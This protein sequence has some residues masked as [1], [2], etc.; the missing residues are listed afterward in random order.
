MS[1]NE[2]LKDPLTGVYSRANLDDRIN[3][4]IEKSRRHNHPFTLVLMDI[5]H[6]K[7]INDGFGHQ[8]GD[9]VLIEFSAR[10][11]KTCRILDLIF[12]FGGDE[13]VIL[14]P[15]TTKSDAAALAARLLEVI[16][17]Q[18]FS[19]QPP[20][21]VSMSIGVSTYPRDG[22]S[23]EQLFE[24]A[25][26]R[27]YQAKR[28]GRACVV[29]EDTPLVDPDSMPA[30]S[31]LLERDDQV[32]ILKQFILNL[33]EQRTGILRIEGADGAGMTRFL[34][35][36]NDIASLQN[37]FSL[38]LVGK[39]G[40][41]QRTL[42]ALRETLL[43]T[44]KE[45]PDFPL[46]TNT[47][48]A[49][50]PQ[51]LHFMAAEKKPCLLITLDETQWIDSATIG[52][53]QNLLDIIQSD[54]NLVDSQTHLALAVISTA[55]EP[56]PHPLF[57]G[58]GNQKKLLLPALSENA[59]SI[60]I[61][62]TLQWE[63]PSDFT[64][65][66]YEETQGLA[67]LI[68]QGLIF[69]VSEKYI[70]PTPGGWQYSPDVLGFELRKELLARRQLSP[71]NLPENL[72]SFVG[73]VEELHYIKQNII[74]KGL[75]TLI[76]P[77]GQGKSRL[78][79]QAA[80][81]NMAYFP[82]GVFIIPLID[83]SSSTMLATLIANSIN[84]SISGPL[85]AD[86][87]LVNYLKNKHMLLVIDNC[88]EYPQGAAQFIEQLTSQTPG[89]K[90]IATSH[91]LLSL[92]D[93]TALKLDGLSYPAKETAEDA[94][95][96]SAIQLFIQSAHRIA[97]EFTPA[98]HLE[99][100]A[101]ICR[102]MD[103]LPL[104][105]ELAA[106][107]AQLF[108]PSEIYRHIENNLSF[109]STSNLDVP[110]RH[111]NLDAIL[112][113][114]WNTLSECNQNVL[115][116]LS[117]FRGGF[118]LQAALE[119]AD[120][121]PFL[122][123]SLAAKSYLSRI[124]RGRFQFH[125]ILRQ[126]TSEK[127]KKQSG[128]I[129]SARNRH[130]N[131]F[132]QFLENRL[133]ALL[134]D[135]QQEA[136]AE[137]SKDIENIRIAWQWAAERGKLDCLTSAMDPLFNYFYILSW[138]REGEE[139]FA[140]V[141]HTLSGGTATANQPIVIARARARQGWFTFLLGDH[142]RAQ[143][144]LIQSMEELQPTENKQDITFCMNY[145]SAIYHEQG[146][147]PAAQSLLEQ[148]LNISRKINDQYS[149]GVALNILGQVVIQL[150]DPHQATE[151]FFEAMRIKRQIGD[152]WGI[153]FTLE[154]LGQILHSQGQYGEAR[155][156]IQ[157]SQSIRQ[158][159]NDQRGVGRCLRALGQIARTLEELEEAASLFR[160]SLFVFETV[161]SQL[162]VLDSTLELARTLHYLERH[163]LAFELF[164]EALNIANLVKIMPKVSDSLIGIANVL[165]RT[166]KPEQALHLAEIVAQADFSSHDTRAAAHTLAESITQMMKPE[167]SQAILES[168]GHSTLD[169]VI[170][171]YIS[172]L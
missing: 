12:R 4:E 17:S 113:S 102:M 120:G 89:I 99:D 37:F 124:S 2:L 9:E 93:E 84:F 15:E 108:T 161:G 45:Y 130:C 55:R 25:D 140:R 80:A 11:A 22:K 109:L 103:G 156:H 133:E 164:K 72:S 148:S 83:I 14:M 168:A 123:D 85:P 61:R 10:L 153:A 143:N 172:V 44:R 134:G 68:Q 49:Y 167:Q 28:S 111:K 56:V 151:H 77:G 126:Y 32:E 136:I 152:N 42:G 82:D 112:S 116:R 62:H 74:E 20:L 41:H 1:Q 30:P 50:A 125:E 88:E 47:P 75:I 5:D 90:I 63:A 114:F 97:P 132:M 165:S 43:S 54:A 101:K 105:I 159:L 31:R 92:P 137:I 59:V 79:V 39:P 52:Y 27:H 110:P 145:L 171:A 53:L 19:G 158:S 33:W 34:E 16:K 142:Q 169:A 96:F 138:F 122:L 3:L 155:R 6:F 23:I 86:Q 67:A 21:S 157:E 69:L 139:T 115:L 147:F 78:A 66:F 65:W 94:T 160:Q 128:A 24:T 87:Q 119:V 58:L 73:R 98:D 141:I 40:L 118:N 131:F 35:E 29:S 127:L 162:D 76:G 91:S 104:G 146:N 36:A 46:L 8:R 163:D 70:N 48:G 60:W 51:L 129:S 166:Q 149:M 18:P 38:A 107:W 154:Y 150:G 121:H 100:I 117:V 135:K 95:T 7:S 26:K 57:R 71:N 64:I 144:L 13:F 170:N 106:S 81:E